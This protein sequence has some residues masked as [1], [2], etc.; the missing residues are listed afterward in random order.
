MVKTETEI[1]ELVKEVMNLLRKHKVTNF[2]IFAI[3]ETVKVIIYA[4]LS[5]SYEG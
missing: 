3:L 2:E 1:N 4:E 5:K